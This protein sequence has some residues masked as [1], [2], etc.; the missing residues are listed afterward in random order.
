MSSPNQ[1]G[2]KQVAKKPWENGWKKQW[3]PKPKD[4]KKGVPT[5]KY[6]HGDFHVFK[7]A[8]STECLTKY[9]NMGTLIELGKYYEKAKPDKRDAEFNTGNTDNNKLLYVEALKGWAKI[10]TDMEMEW[11]GHI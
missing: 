5:L 6:G 9:G 10:K 1:G 3:N 7:E 2:N 8:L 11:S 4:E